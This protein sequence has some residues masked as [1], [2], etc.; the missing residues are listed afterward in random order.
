MRVESIFLTKTIEQNIKQLGIFS[1][2]SYNIKTDGLRTKNGPIDFAIS[3]AIHLKKSKLD[4]WRKEK[5]G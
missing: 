1:Q 5:G 2:A 4:L 3:L